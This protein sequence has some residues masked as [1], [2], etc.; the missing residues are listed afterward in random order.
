MIRLVFLFCS[1]TSTVDLVTDFLD[2]CLNLACL[3]SDCCWHDYGSF[4]FNFFFI[5]WLI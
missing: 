5:E 4:C 2:A 1:A 3:F